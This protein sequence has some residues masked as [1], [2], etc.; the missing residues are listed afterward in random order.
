MKLEEIQ[1]LVKTINQ[2]NIEKFKFKNNEVELEIVNRSVSNQINEQ[3]A[4]KIL[5]N[6]KE[7]SKIKEMA[8]DS[9]EKIKS[10]LVGVFYEA[11]GPN[12]EAFVVEGQQV[13]KGEV[14]CIIEAM[15][16]MNEIVAKKDCIIKK[17]LPSNEDIVEYDQAL[18]LIE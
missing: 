16:V 14:I 17:I 10:P 18:F 5:S 2:S 6:E 7:L 9:S 12:E 11:S 15:K 4:S 1:L 13:K 3:S 8:H